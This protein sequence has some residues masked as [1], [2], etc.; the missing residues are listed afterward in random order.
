M[1]PSVVV[2]P[3]CEALAL[4]AIAT[5]RVPFA[6][7]DTNVAPG[8]FVCVHDAPPSVDLPATPAPPVVNNVPP[9][10][11]M[12]L[13]DGDDDMY[14]QLIPSVDV[15]G[16]ELRATS[17]V[18]VLIA[19]VHPLAGNVCCVQLI[20]SGLVKLVVP[21]E[22]SMTNRLPMATA[23]IPLIATPTGKD[24]IVHVMPSGLVA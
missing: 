2:K 22:G 12:A 17:L 9:I 11:V 16:D 23:F 13:P 14:C 1:T 3:C 20:P 10:D 15:I 24:R 5:A 4:P 7:I 8:T 6:A 18:P 21:C 19:H